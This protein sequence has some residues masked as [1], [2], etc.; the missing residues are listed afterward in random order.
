MMRLS[1][2][3]ITKSAN[4]AWL[5]SIV[6]CQLQHNPHRK[7]VCSLQKVARLLGRTEGSFQRV[8]RGLGILR[9]PY[10]VRKSLQEI[11]AK[12]REYLVSHAPPHLMC[13]S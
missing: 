3:L 12:T 5:N 13:F 1:P 7:R 4:T 6:H 2:I 9:W 8:C 11:M 10:R